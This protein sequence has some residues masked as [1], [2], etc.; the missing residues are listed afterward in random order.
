MVEVRD[1]EQGPLVITLCETGTQTE[2]EM[3]SVAV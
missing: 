3:V 2:I 1:S